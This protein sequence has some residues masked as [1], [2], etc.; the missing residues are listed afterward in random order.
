M[1]DEV[2]LIDGNSVLYRAFFALPLLS[3]DQGVHTNAVYGFTT[4][5]LKILEEKIQ[6]IFWLPLMRAKRHSVMRLIK[7]IKVVDK[8]HHL[9][10]LNNS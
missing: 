3:N 10:F 5:L 8:K 4:M 7:N 2:I 6:K 9:N 1:A